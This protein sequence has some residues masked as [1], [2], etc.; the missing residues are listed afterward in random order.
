MKLSSLFFLLFSILLLFFNGLLSNSISRI[1]DVSIVSDADGSKN[2][3]IP[4]GPPAGSKNLPVPVGAP[5]SGSLLSR[6]IKHHPSLIA[7][8]D[9][10]IYLVDLNSGK[11]HWSLDLGPALSSSYQAFSDHGSD[12]EF[13]NGIGEQNESRP[14]LEN[15]FIEG[16][17]DGYLYEHTKLFGKM[18]LQLT[19]R[20]YVDRTP[21]ISA[22]GSVILGSKT[23]T[24][25]IVDAKSG[26]VIRTFQLTD[27][28][29]VVGVQSDEAKLV[30]FKQGVEDWIKSS[31][32]DSK[33]FEL[34]FI[35]RE[36]YTLQCFHPNSS[37]ILWNTTVAEI[38]AVYSC[39]GLGK[40]FDGLP[41]NSED[42]L[43]LEYQGDFEMP[44][45]CDIPAIVY[46]I[47]DRDMVYFRLNNLLESH[48]EGEVLPLPPPE[49]S[50][51]SILDPHGE[52]QRLFDDFKNSRDTD[53]NTLMEIDDAH[54]LNV[55]S[56]PEVI[57]WSYVHI[58][59][60]C[61]VAALVGHNF[62]YKVTNAFL[63]L[64]QSCLV[65]W[66][67]LMGNKKDKSNMQLTDLSRKQDGVSKRKKARRVGT[68]KNGV[69]VN[70][71]DEHT[72]SEDVKNSTL[73][74]VETNDWES[75]M[76][77]TKAYEDGKGRWV[78]KL[79]VSNIEIA[80]GSN[81]TVVFE[82]VYGVYERPIKVAVKRLVLAHN[83]IAFKEIENLMASS[84][85][86]NIV[87]LYGVER[88]LDFVYLSLERCSCSLD[89]LIQVCSENSS[90]PLFC[91]T[92]ASNSIREYSVRLD[93]IQG[94]N[95][96]IELWKANGYPS[97]LLLK[98]M[99]DVVSGLAHLHKMGII[100][101]D[102]K[103]QNVLISGEESLRAKL[104]DMG[105]SK[106]LHGDMSS[107]GH[108]TGGCGSSG[109]RAPEQLLQGRQTR[110]V[111][112][113]S[114]GCLLFSCITG[115][116][117]PFGESLERDV[118]IANNH[119]DLFL[120]E[121]IPEAV[122]LFSH[123]L[124]PDPQQRPKAKEVLHHPFFWN[125]EKHL[126][127]LRD[128]SDKI[129][130]EDESESDILKTIEN[131]A[132]IALGGK[133]DDKMEAA[134]ITN[135]GRYRRYKYDSTRDLLRVIRNKL[136]HYGELPNDVQVCILTSTR[137]CLQSLLY[138]APS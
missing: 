69:I 41:F 26:R 127:F 1:G 132:P 130:L 95:K 79:F 119:V 128:A 6:P 61:L 109:W 51:P 115:G 18:R 23:T 29:P 87:R 24:V 34:L 117:H 118:N 112:L 58:C 20:E 62:G 126:S 19:A 121:H 14:Y 15:Y 45:P 85:H 96:D 101:R 56:I 97:S 10:T 116:K 37:K 113:F 100:H 50:N 30:L 129:E 22:D 72:S 48:R 84:E 103:P 88:D 106:R 135:I 28:Q 57:G 133:W 102:L 94:I 12:D 43:A 68:I 76:N 137:T 111:D 59:F 78:G 33:T 75:S 114:L 4:V 5:A 122:H 7:S 73:R 16:G 49:T 92:L 80:K 98:L 11:V 70:R 64:V 47:C 32:A 44:L 90:G 120:V 74:N 67:H 66:R 53:N 131:V 124:H 31:F 81:G 54:H 17:D 77:L 60:I 21:H 123:L 46:R 136:N 35:K 65:A 91:K 27:I 9:G 52:N 55:T 3:P 110:A 86:P 8:S 36:D 2:L 99:R 42:Q 108:Y 71:P 82:G 93:L 105:I 38:S 39:Q 89:D 40:S 13:G 134:F 25:F 107:F 83:D 125:Y 138:Q 104:S 63:I